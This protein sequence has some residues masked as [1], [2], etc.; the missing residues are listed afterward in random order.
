M[1][2]EGDASTWQGLKNIRQSGGGIAS[3]PLPRAAGVYKHVAGLDKFFR[4]EEALL[5]EARHGRR[6]LHRG[7]DGFE[8]F[9]RSFLDLIEQRHSFQRNESDKYV[10]FEA[11]AYFARLL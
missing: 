4:R 2:A 1:R 8:P 3:L 9:E 5:F 6:R 11:H 7:G 10:P